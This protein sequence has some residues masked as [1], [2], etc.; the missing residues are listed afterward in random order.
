VLCASQVAACAALTNLP[1]INQVRDALL[2]ERTRLFE[3]LQQVSWLEPY[4]SQANFILCKVLE[5]RCQLACM[6]QYVLHACLICP[7]CVLIAFSHHFSILGLLATCRF[8]T[9]HSIL[10]V[11]CL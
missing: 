3:Q 2:S 9:L 8:L 7:A 1:Y 11:T 6:Q 5:V 10:L 4:P